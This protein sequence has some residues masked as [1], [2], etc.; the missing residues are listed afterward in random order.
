MSIASNSHEY[1]KCGSRAVQVSLMSRASVVH[2]LVLQALQ[3]KKAGLGNSSRP[4]LLFI[5]NVLSQTS[6]GIKR[7]KRMA[8]QTYSQVLATQL[9]CQLTGIIVEI[10]SYNQIF[11]IRRK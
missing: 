3:N 4:A 9:N 2:G 7:I 11:V 8:L 10:G 1:C 6:F 5:F